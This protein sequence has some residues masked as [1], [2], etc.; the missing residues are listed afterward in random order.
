MTDRS[1]SRGAILSR[2]AETFRG[3]GYEGASLARLSRAAGL[4]KASLYHHF[5]G[6]KAEMAE[7]VLD[8]LATRFGELVF[9]P[10][11]GAEPIEARVN[12]FLD[13][14]A[15]HY[16]N[17]GEPGLF[18]L[19]SMEPARERFAPRIAA[20]YGHWI[21]SLS[22]LFVETGEDGDEAVRRAVDA[23]A[24]L[25]GS[26]V[27]SRALEDSGPFR[28]AMRQIRDSLA[29]A[30]ADGG[31]PQPAV[32]PE[33]DGDD[34]FQA[35]DVTF[36]EIE[37]VEDAALQAGDIVLGDTAA[38][39]AAALHAGDIVPGDTAADGDDAL[40]ADDIVPGHT[41]T[42]G[43]AALHAGEIVL[44]DG[45]AGGS[46]AL[47]V[48]EIGLDDTAADGDAAF[49]AAGTAPGGFEADGAASERESGE[50][51]AIAGDGDADTETAPAP[52]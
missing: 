31:A 14:L 47:Q 13:I 9:A 49:Q 40:Q 48:G 46:D 7:A 29:P 17:G 21:A 26:V 6:G 43:D 35:A 44:D 38:D 20:F 27:L 10:L 1:V 33:A 3:C 8:E 15:G 12:A 45:D 36:D 28:R 11:G 23:I 19:F 37:A 42:D 51:R 4:Q 39:G 34:A 22:A 50:N 18:A 41:A 32:A 25:E 52:V 5:P 30:H 16:E 2:L 24:L